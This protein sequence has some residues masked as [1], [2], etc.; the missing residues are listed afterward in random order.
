MNARFS[1]L[2]KVILVTLAVYVGQLVIGALV[3][4]L[5]G[6]VW[7]HAPPFSDTALP[8]L[9]GVLLT[10]AVLVYPAMRSTLHGWRL[11]L[12]VF[13]AL[14][15]LNV[16]LLNIEGAIFLFMT[17]EQLTLIVL[18]STLTNALLA[19]LMTVVFGRH[20]SPERNLVQPGRPRTA[21]KWVLVA[22]L[23]SICYMVLYF[24]AGLMII[25]FVRE[26]YETQH[27]PTGAWFIPFQVLRGVGY[28]LFTLYLVRSISGS[29]WLCSLS[30]GLM[31]PVLAGV[32]GL[33]S[34]NGIMPDHVRYWHMLEIGWSNLV[35][36]MIVGYVFW[37]GGAP[38]KLPAGD[39]EPA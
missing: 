29:R 31:F 12:A 26:F 13:L 9:A 4:G 10:V 18:Y 35:F 33:L 1:I 38:E 36:G 17:P 20:P 7:E 24:A 2:L 25:P 11:F 30:M 6:P 21:G 34:P 22:G 3:Y 16:V 28:I 23:L 8:M 32:A 14:F 27:I 39:F 37:N 5:M 15:G 19:L